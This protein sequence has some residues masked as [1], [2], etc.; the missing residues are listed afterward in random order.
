MFQLSGFY[1]I[2]SSSQEFVAC[3]DFGLVCLMNLRNPEL[4]PLEK[5]LN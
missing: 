4:L 5:H 3:L 1:S 2:P